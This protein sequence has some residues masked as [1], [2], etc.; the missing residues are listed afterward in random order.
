MEWEPINGKRIAGVSSFGFSGTNAHVILEEP[1]AEKFEVKSETSDRPA[2]VLCVS[3]K[4]EESLRELAE[5][6]ASLIEIS[7]G[8]FGGRLLYERRGS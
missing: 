6:Y 4:Q 2:H 8:K 1:P 3:A 7:I 5:R